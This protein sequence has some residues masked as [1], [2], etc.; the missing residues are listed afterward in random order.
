MLSLSFERFAQSV[1]YCSLDLLDPIVQEFL[2][3]SPQSSFQIL[4]FLFSILFPEPQTACV[5]YHCHVTSLWTQQAVVVTMPSVLGVYFVVYQ[6]VCRSGGWCQ[7]WKRLSPILAAWM[8]NICTYPDNV[9][10]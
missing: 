8:K 4:A 3:P 2:K 5:S 7:S 1:R 6:L 9:T 10:P